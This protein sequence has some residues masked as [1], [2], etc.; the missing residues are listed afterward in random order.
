MKIIGDV[1]LDV[2][3]Q[4]NCTKVSPEASALVLKED[5]RNYNVGGAGNLAL[6]LSNL[7]VDTH[8]YSSV[9][10]DAPGHKIQEI[11]LKNNIKTFISS[12]AKTS[13]VKT[14]MIGS[15]GQHL[16]RLDKEDKYTDSEPT[17]NLI[18]N[19]QKDDIVLISDYD[20]GV[21]SHSI[22][23]DI[24]SLVKRVYVDPKQQPVNYK[25]AYLVKP[26]MKEYEQWFGKF[27]KENADQ[28]RKEFTWE[29]LVITDG[30][31]GIH[32]VGENTYEHITGDS[33][34]L[35]DVSGAGD[36]VLAVIVKYVEQGTNIIDACKLALK[37]A[38]AVVQHRGVTVVQL[39]D[40]EDTVVWTN[41]VFDILH[42]GHLEL[43]KFSKSQG[44][45]LIVGI[46]SDESVK[47]LK[48]DDRPFNNAWVREQQL[49]QLPW[50]D[51]VV[52]FE[53]DTPIEAIQQH[54]PNVIIKGGD[55]TVE[56]TVGN[57]LADVIIFPTVKGFSTTNIVDKVNEQRNKK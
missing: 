19:L 26:N 39:S 5:K 40:I 30:G 34:E 6:N 38:S 8:L 54:K 56:T 41:G 21:I 7:G 43:L 25:G 28:F 23:E 29:W 33:V 15:D 9:G 57:E 36:T 16:L 14:R 52:V 51:Q 53:E 18:K 12:D 13:T 3:V 24:V 44:D 50:V 35:A 1:M 27:T 55:Y 32:V 48:G 37:G 31:N 4:G 11:L 42:Q 22:V 46:N 45:K 2:W 20:K 47:R 49:L 17:K 10:N